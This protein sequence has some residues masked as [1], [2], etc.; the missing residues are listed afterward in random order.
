MA[1]RGLFGGVLARAAAADAVTDHG[2]LQAMLDAEAALA[3]ALADRGLL[4]RDAGDRIVAAADAARFDPDALGAAAAA[5]AGNPVPALVRALTAAVDGEAPVA[6]A[7]A[8]GV[9]RGATSQDVLDSAAMLVARRATAEILI[10]LEAAAG[11]CAALAREHRTTAAIGRTL[12]QQATPTSFGLRCATWL[13]GLDEAAAELAAARRD[14]LAAQLGGAVGTLAPLGDAGPEVADAFARR[15]GLAAP[16]LPWHTVR[17]RPL[18]LAGALATVAAITGKIAGDVVLLAQTEVAEVHEQG[19]PGRGGSSTMPHKRNPVAAVSARAAAVRVPGLVATLLA[20]ADQPQERAAGHW[21]AEWEAWSDLLRLTGV[22]V[23]WLREALDRLRVDRE[24]VAAALAVTHGLVLAEAAASA[25]APALGRVPAHDL[26]ADASRRAAAEDRPLAAVLAAEPAVR[27]A[28][29]DQA[30]ADL[31][32]ALDPARHLGA[33]PVFVDRALAAH[34][35]RPGPRPGRPV[36]LAHAVDGPTDGPAVVLLHAIGSDRR[37]WDGCLAPLTAAGLRVVA[38]DLRGHGRSPVPPGPYAFGDLAGDVL[39]LLDALAVA[40][41]SV[42]GVS[43]GGAVALDLALRAPG[44]I[45]RVAACCTGARI[46]G[47][48]V[49]H[50]RAAIVSEQGID[51]LTEGALDRWVTAAF[52]STEPE[53][54]ATLLATLRATPAAGYAGCAAALADLDLRPALGR[55]SAPTLIVAGAEDVATPPASHAEPLAAAIP[56]ARLE[57]VPGTAHLAPFERPDLVGPLLAGFLT[58]PTG[59]DR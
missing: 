1:D 58:D 30:E 45:D 12:L 40:R 47:P 36:P 39:A 6:R 16:T 56:G 2:W 50:E 28:L 24:A 34:E 53:R 46:Y 20:A 7:A 26:V 51:P 14:A 57:V 38:V 41:A 18:R 11:R 32:E 55:L 15:L 8:A 4:E 3:L 25:L 19:G 37:L 43:L 17:V 52:R 49:W 9:H 5:G 31:R 23:A 33:A 29:G 10:D 42:A 35:R 59:G 44:R 22:A 48:T 54:A 27:D 21:Q 13:N